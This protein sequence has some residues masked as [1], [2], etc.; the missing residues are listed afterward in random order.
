MFQVDDLIIYGGTGVCRVTAV[1]TREGRSFYTLDPVYGTETIY[2]PADAKVFMR[3]VLT[4]AEAEDLIAQIPSI[5]AES[6]AGKNLQLL[7]RYYQEALQSHQCTDLIRLIKTIYNRN[8]S[9]GRDTKKPY[10]LDETYRKRA[11]DLLH[12]ELAVS[13]EIPR[14]GVEAYIAQR[15]APEGLP[16]A[17]AG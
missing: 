13:L 4:R 11:E 5:D 2:V 3:P 15:I 10:K 8:N 14:E 6:V 12:G 1:D 9:T 16:E 17:D 7:G